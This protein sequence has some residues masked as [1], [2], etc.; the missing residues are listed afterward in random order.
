MAAVTVKVWF[1][2]GRDQIIVLD[3]P[4]ALDMLPGRLETEF[5]RIE[6]RHGELVKL[7]EITWQ[8]V[9]PDLS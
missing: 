5:S 2:T 4:M 9:L 3:E 7:V 8:P 6:R 1:T